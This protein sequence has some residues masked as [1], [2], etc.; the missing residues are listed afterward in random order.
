LGVER[1]IQ[2]RLTPGIEPI[3]REEHGEEE[4]DHRI[5][6]ERNPE[7]VYLGFPG[8]MTGSSHFGSI[9]TDHLVGIGHEKRDGHADQGKHEEAN[10]EMKMLSI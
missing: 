3:T 2:G 6:S 9:C 10:L 4:D 8:R 1:R 5:R 7:P